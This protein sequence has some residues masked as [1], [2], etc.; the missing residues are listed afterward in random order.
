MRMFTKRPGHLQAGQSLMELESEKVRTSPT[1]AYFIITMVGTIIIKSGC[2]D[3]SLILISRLW[4]MVRKFLISLPF[5]RQ[6]PNTSAKNF[7]EDLSQTY[8]LQTLCMEQL[9]FGS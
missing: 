8:H 3:L 4:L 6:R 2:L 9:K 1:P 5:T 7:V